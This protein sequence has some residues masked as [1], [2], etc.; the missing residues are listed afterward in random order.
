MATLFV[1]KDKGGTGRPIHMTVI[2]PSQMVPLKTLKAIGGEGIDGIILA[3]MI[4]AIATHDRAA[5]R[6]ARAALEQTETPE[7]R[8][9][10]QALAKLYTDR[11]DTL[12]SLLNKLKLP[13][14]YTSPA[15][16]MA[17]YVAESLTR[18][19]LLSGSIDPEALEFTLLD[20]AFTL[21]E[22]TLADTQALAAIAETAKPSSTITALAKAV[23]TMIGGLPMLEKLREA[24]TNILIAVVTVKHP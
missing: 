11:V 19:P 9:L 10:H 8:K 14:L 6:F 13:R 3:D 18:A 24:R 23:K 16:R 15:S 17:G 2:V 5:A 21:A 20:I 4:S 1:T 7:L 12:E 22:R